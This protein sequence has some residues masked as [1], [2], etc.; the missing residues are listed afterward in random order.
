M[1]ILIRN[2]TGNY[3]NSGLGVYSSNPLTSYF[4]MAGV[5]NATQQDIVT[6]LYNNL[7]SANLLNNVFNINLPVGTNGTGIVYNM[8]DVGK[9]KWRLVGDDSSAYSINGYKFQ[10]GRYGFHDGIVTDANLAGGF[11]TILCTTT[12]ES[13]NGIRVSYGVYDAYVLA[14]S[15]YDASGNIRVRNGFVPDLTSVGRTGQQ[16]IGFIGTKQNSGY[17]SN[18]LW[19][20]A[21]KLNAIGTNSNGIP[22]LPAIPK[23]P[24]IG[25]WNDT[26]NA[27]NYGSDVTMGM[28]VNFKGLNDAQYIQLIGF[29]KTAA[30][31]LGLNGANNY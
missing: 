30:I 22:A 7:V 24:A 14:L 19:I 26:N 6:T 20:G 16:T 29:L 10:Y 11:G 27:L 23:Q 12:E 17:T 15:R 9:Y 21:T 2:K 5:T 25:I 3:S 13:Y 18:E 4:S 8:L 28:I 31:A 1:G